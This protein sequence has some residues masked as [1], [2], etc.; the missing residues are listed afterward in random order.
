MIHITVPVL[1]LEA[2]SGSDTVWVH[3][4]KGATVLRLKCTG[5]I[6]IDRACANPVAHADLLVEGDIR[7]CLPPENE[8]PSGLVAVSRTALDR[9][10]WLLVNRESQS[11]LVNEE[12]LLALNNSQ[13]IL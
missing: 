9:L 2:Y 11:E 13:M 7:L 10:R 5:E 1:Q 12:A 3:S 6:V 4:P 8:D